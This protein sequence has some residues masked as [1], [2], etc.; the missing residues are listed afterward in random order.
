MSDQFIVIP[1]RFRGPPQSGNG[2]YVCGVLAG[3]L[4]GGRYALPDAKAVEVS[5]RSR[6][7]LDQ[8]IA[9]RPTQSALVA[10]AGETLIAEASLAT[11][12]I[13]VPEPASF[14]EALAVRERSPSLEMRMHPW[15]KQERK[16]FHPICFCCGAE[17]APD[18]G[19]HV[20]AAKVDAREQ[21]AAAWTCHPTFADADG[22]LPGAIVCAALDCPGQFAW[23]AQGTRTGLLGRMTARIER[24]VRA[25]ERCVVIGWT[26]GNE[27]RKF[28][29]GTALFDS[30]NTLCAYAK[31][32]WIGVP[33]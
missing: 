5:L 16:G 7:P 32:V 21:V 19:L 24:R 1:E 22:Y 11:L 30:N 15:L 20:Y 31:A 25:G 23:L 10:Y 4:S 9:V 12:Q 27:G 6:V 3:L 13:E 33:T 18:E 26:M 2:G 28:Y 14:D 17:L 29:A 8:A